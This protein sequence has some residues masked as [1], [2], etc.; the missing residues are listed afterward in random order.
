MKIEEQVCSLELAKKLKELGLTQDGYFYWREGYHTEESFK[1]GISLGKRG[2]FE[3]RY[4]I[5][6]DPKP[7]YTTAVVKWNE[8]D[9][10][11]LYE[12]ECARTPSP[13]SARCC[14][15]M[16]TTLDTSMFLT[17]SAKDKDGGST[18]RIAMQATPGAKPMPAPRC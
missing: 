13:S 3:G 11:R 17:V 1:K 9:L 6:A 7:R 18:S 15:I 12:T 14:L 8:R 10:S 16:S 5:V 4:R 2:V